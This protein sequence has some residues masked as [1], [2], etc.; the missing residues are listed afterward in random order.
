MSSRLLLVI[1]CVVSRAQLSSAQAAV[2]R[3]SVA[4]ALFVNDEWERY[5][6]VRQVT[7][8]APEYPWSV[9]AFGPR[10]S[11]ATSIVRR[12]HP[13]QGQSLARSIKF[14]ALSLTTL[15]A[16]TQLILNSSFPFGYN[17]GP[18]WA[19]RGLTTVLQGGIS[20]TAGV[21]SATFAPIVFR[22]E[23]ASFRLRDNGMSGIYAFG[24]AFVPLEI[25]Q[26]QR[27]GDRPY[28]RASMGNSTVRVDVAGITTGLST[29]NQH[30]GPARDNPMLLGNNAGGFPHVF[31]G[32]SRPLDLRILKAHGKLIWGRLDASPYTTMR[33]EER[34]RFASGIVGIITPA[35][36]PNLELGAGR[37]FHQVW[38]ADVLTLA[39]IARPFIGII[40]DYRIRASGNAIGDE[41]DN[42]IAS[43]FGRW[44]FP[45]SGF[46]VY[47]EFAKE[48]YNKD[49][50]DLAMEPDHIGGYMFGLQ[51]VI[52]RDSTS[53][54]VVRSELLNT[55]ISP[56][57][58]NRFQFPFYVHGRVRE[59]HT[60]NGQ[61]LGS[62]AGFGGGAATIGVDRYTT[63]G[64]TTLSWSRML[65]A[66][67]RPSGIGV[68]DAQ[69]ADLF[70]TLT[71]DGLIFRGRTAITYELTGVYELNR[72]FQK[73]AFNVRAATGLQ[74]AW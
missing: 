62:V 21:F 14:G 64:R 37:F 47:G 31:L 10:E 13:W 6:R 66:E 39:N 19:G 18:V 1:A 33:Q 60:N 65:R 43:I 11:V 28:Q 38:S 72:D 35:F 49:F 8:D 53:Y 71:V 59:G 45:K 69:R 48:D 27:Y 17:D 52:K 57:A 30:W 15:P 12:A 26:P 42:Q 74:Y 24:D 55:R 7:G 32:T 3:D 5:A 16:S 54:F 29:A 40:R 56:L 41:P 22:S 50:R 36:A 20:A 63:A 44:V 68:P 58:L 67:Y 9:R 34:Y 61:V 70:Q 73:D 23:N 51:R 4:P 46:E 2:T 25:D